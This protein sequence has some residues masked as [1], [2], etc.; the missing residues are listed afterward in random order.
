MN[1]WIDKMMSQTQILYCEGDNNA[2]MMM[3]M[4]VSV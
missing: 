1:R 4:F 2:M 3:M